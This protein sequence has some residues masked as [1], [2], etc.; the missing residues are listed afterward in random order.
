MEKG[1]VQAQMPDTQIFKVCGHCGSHMTSSSV[2]SHME[3]DTEE[4]GLAQG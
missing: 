2:I 3:K 1:Q 4:S